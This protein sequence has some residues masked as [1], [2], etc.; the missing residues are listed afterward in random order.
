MVHVK[1]CPLGDRGQS[2]TEFFKDGKPQKYCYG[3]VDKMNDEP[4]EVCKRCL[5][6]VGGEQIRKD[7]KSACTREDVR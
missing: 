7:L 5:D 1:E 6:Y 2:T 4:L 3:R